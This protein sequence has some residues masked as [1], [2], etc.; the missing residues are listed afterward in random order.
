MGEGG[1]GGEWEGR[2]GGEG[3]EVLGGFEGKGEDGGVWVVVMGVEGVGVG[4]M[5][6]E[7]GN[8]WVWDGKGFFSCGVRLSV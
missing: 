7:R 3:Q 8:Q 5:G 4:E 6:R 2:Q 1:G